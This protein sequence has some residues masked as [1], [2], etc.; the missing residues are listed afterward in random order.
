MTNS[1]Q[2]CPIISEQVR[3]STNTNLLMEIYELV[4]D[5]KIPDMVMCIIRLHILNFEDLCYTQDVTALQEGKKKDMV[6]VYPFQF[7]IN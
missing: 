4:I 2:I 1:I 5:F 7:I 3:D 6:T